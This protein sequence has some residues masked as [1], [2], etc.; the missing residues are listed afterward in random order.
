MVEWGGSWWARVCHDGV[1]W[2]MVGWDQSWL[3]QV[4]HVRVEWGGS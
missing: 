4:G 1:G 3:G 2:V